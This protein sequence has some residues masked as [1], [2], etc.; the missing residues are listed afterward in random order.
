MADPKNPIDWAGIEADYCKSDTPIR[1][2]SRWYQ[3]S[4]TAIR[5]RAKAQGWVRPESAAPK[6]KQEPLPDASIM[7]GVDA[8]KPENIVGRGQNLILRLLDEL[9]ATTTHQGELADLIEAH[10]DDPRRKAAMLKAIELPSRANVIKALA[11]AFK[12]WS[13]TQAMVP[14][15]KKA[16]RKATA[17]DKAAQGGKFAP[18]TAPKLVVSNR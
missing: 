3:I 2:L 5:K 9:D 7:A 8:T 1:E 16:Q 17:E 6:P 15:G 14:E 12:T 10:E 11:T 4:D 13:E 18:P